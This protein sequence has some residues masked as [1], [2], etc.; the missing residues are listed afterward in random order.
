VHRFID[1]LFVVNTLDD[2]RHAGKVL[3]ATDRIDYVRHQPEPF[4]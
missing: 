4:Q 3:I 1:S 2:Y